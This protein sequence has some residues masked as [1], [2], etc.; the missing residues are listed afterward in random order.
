MT[1]QCLRGTYDI[2]ECDLSDSLVV[3]VS[4]PEERLFISAGRGGVLLRLVVEQGAEGRVPDDGDVVGLA[5]CYQ[6]WLL[7]VQVYLG[8]YHQSDIVSKLQSS[9]GLLV[10]LGILS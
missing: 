5:V 1:E 9:T 2:S 10:N 4:D 6:L 3:L 7:E 8:T